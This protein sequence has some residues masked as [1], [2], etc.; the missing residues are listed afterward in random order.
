MSKSTVCLLG[1]LLITVVS[2]FDREAA[3]ER[4]TSY[5]LRSQYLHVEHIEEELDKLE[6]E[7]DEL[8]DPVEQSEIQ[9]VKARVKRLERKWI[10]HQVSQLHNLNI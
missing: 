7:F 9:R 10:M 4:V 8:S 5:R 3:K 6:A 2:G 1:L